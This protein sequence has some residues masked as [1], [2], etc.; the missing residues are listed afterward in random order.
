MGT[1]TARERNGAI[2]RFKRTRF[3]AWQKRVLSLRAPILAARLSWYRW[4]RS[5]RTFSFDGRTYRYFYHPYNTAWRTE[6]TVEVPIV[7]ELVRENRGRRIL[8]VGNVLS[9]YFPVSHEIV[10]KYERGASVRNEDVVD[11]RPEAPYDLIV[12]ISTLE[13]VGMDEEEKE[14]RKPLRAV[15]HLGSLLAPGGRLVVTIPLGQNPELDRMLGD[16]EI[17]FTR[18][19]CLKRISAGNDWIET[20]WESIRGSRHDHPFRAANGL[21]VGII[22]RAGF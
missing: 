11:I 14:P 13:H 7:W 19:L 16:G 17:P 1:G 5:G 9:H 10:D 12:S 22:E 6:R 3:Y 21:V 18:L 4:F 20:D 8:E 15:R 2:F